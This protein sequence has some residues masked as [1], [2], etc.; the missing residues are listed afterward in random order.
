MLKKL[1]HFTLQLI[2]G[3]NIATILLMLAVGYSDHLSPLA[4]PTLSTAGLAFPAVLAV[5]VAFLLFWLLAKPL[6]ALIPVGGL[7]L[8]YQ[9]VHHYFPINIPH[10]AGTDSTLVVLTFNA[11]NQEALPTAD[12]R[13]QVAD[14]LIEQDADIIC[15]QE[16]QVTEGI[17]EK[18]SERYTYID[19]VR[20]VKGG[21][22]LTLISKYPILSK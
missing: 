2:A 13:Q 3:A 20:V 19:S 4:F 1:K 21:D 6:Y 9:P 18:L 5:N 17:A 10:S 15:L 7:L 12:F 14:Y 22:A 8:A 16:F 11:H